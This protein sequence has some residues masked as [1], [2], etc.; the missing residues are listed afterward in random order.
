MGDFIH[1]NPE[2]WVNLPNLT[3]TFTLE[4]T[5]PHTAKTHLKENKNL[6]FTAAATKQ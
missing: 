6:N 3:L 1:V 5:R 2:L 4:E